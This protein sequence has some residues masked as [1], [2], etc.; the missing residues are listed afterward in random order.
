MSHESSSTVSKVEER[1]PTEIE[2]SN[3]ANVGTGGS[4]VSELKNLY[5]Q[6]M[7]ASR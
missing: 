1:K 5:E 2:E 3:K 7:A 4:K 6:K